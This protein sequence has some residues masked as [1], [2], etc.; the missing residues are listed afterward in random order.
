[1]ETDKEEFF[2]LIEDNIERNIEKKLLNE[3]VKLYFKK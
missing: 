3:I 1:M 2:K